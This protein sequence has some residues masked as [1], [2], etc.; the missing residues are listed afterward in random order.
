MSMPSAR[1]LSSTG[2]KTSRSSSPS[3]PPSPAWGFRPASASRGRAHSEAGKLGL[4]EPDGSLQTLRRQH[5]RYVGERNVHGRQHHRQA[6]GV[7]HHPDLAGAGQLREQLG[8]SAPAQPGA[9]PRPLVDGSGGQAVDAFRQRIP[10]G[11]HDESGTRA[12]ARP[13]ADN[14]TPG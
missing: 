14:T 10:R 2:A 1:Q 6:L 7:E 8:M 5:R 3:S 11:P 9:R 12:R 13:A 4:R